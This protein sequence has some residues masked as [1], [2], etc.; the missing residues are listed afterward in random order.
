MVIYVNLCNKKYILIPHVEIY[1][2]YNT[3]YR[4]RVIKQKEKIMSNT[5]TI[6]FYNSNKIG[7]SPAA[8]I[9]TIGANC[10][11][12]PSIFGNGF[13][14]APKGPST[15]EKVAA[16]VTIATTGVSMIASVASLVKAFGSLS[17]GKSGDNAAD[18]LDQAMAAKH[19]R[20]SKINN[21]IQTSNATINAN[22]A[23]IASMTVK[24]QVAF[25]KAKE[26]LGAKGKEAS[27][28]KDVQI[29]KAKSTLDKAT[30]AVEKQQEVVNTAKTAV[31]TAKSNLE[32]AKSNLAAIPDTQENAAA[33]TTAQEA[34]SRCETEKNNAEAAQ[35]KAENDQT[36]LDTKAKTAADE[37]T[38]LEGQQKVIEKELINA[39]NEYDTAQ[40]N[41]TQAE[42]VKEQLTQENETIQAKITQAESI[43]AQGTTSGTEDK[44]DSTATLASGKSASTTP[45]VLFPSGST[46]GRTSI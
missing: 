36:D 16:G 18:A 9:A 15:L 24:E 43:L 11:A 39:N 30:A 17:G 14:S 13:S 40:V 34:V 31:T 23:K 20:K 19:G 29:P 8:N 42:K 3:L 4:Y 35:T 38:K 21:A 32:K 12:P 25:D 41:L 26:K 7:G 37:Y 10:A 2:L 1:I 46:Y 28:M 33:R 6:D 22:K 44:E 5:P 27:D 45:P